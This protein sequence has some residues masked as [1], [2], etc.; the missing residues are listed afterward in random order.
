MIRFNCPQ[1]GK[2]LKAGPEQAGTRFK[3]TGCG[4]TS[5][6]P[7]WTNEVGGE[8]AQRAGRAAAA[9]WQASTHDEA[10]A[11][12]KFGKRLK[13]DSEMDMTPMVDVTFQLLIFF[14]ITASYALQKSLEVPRP[15]TEAPVAQQRVPEQL[16]DDFIVVRIDEESL[17]WVNDREAPTRQELIARLRDELG[18]G[19]SAPQGLLVSY[20]PD[21]RHDRVVRC[22]DV[23]TLL[24]IEKIT[25]RASVEGSE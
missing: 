21:A 16:E 23:G 2:K 17:I 1:C 8:D 6:V 3:C 4:T 10:M 22:I 14:M 5:R 11:P 25:K 9:A 20:H 19:R 15:D 7:R 24:G 12:V 13:T 18:S